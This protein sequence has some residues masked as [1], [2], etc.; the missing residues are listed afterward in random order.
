[1]SETMNVAELAFAVEYFLGPFSAEAETFGKG[2]EELDDLGDVVV[3]FAVF[4]AGLGIEEIISGDELKYL[5][6]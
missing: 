1:V 3:V 2:T 5:V 6:L 4:S